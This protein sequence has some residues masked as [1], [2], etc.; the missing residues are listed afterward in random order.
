MDESDLKIVE[1]LACVRCRTQAQAA[2]AEDLLR[3]TCGQDGV[4]HV[5]TV[6]APGE[7][8]VP[9]GA[10]PLVG[11]TLGP[12][13][14][15]RRAGSEGGLPLYHGLDVNLNQ[16]H[17]VRV[18]AGESAR[19]RGQLQ[20][21]I[22]AG[23]MAAAVRHAAVATVIHLGRLE[24]GG[25]FTVG[26][27]LE[28]ESFGQAV[29]GSRRLG[30]H[31]V[32]RV[33]R[34]LAE[35]LALLHDKRIVHRNLG[36]KSVYLLP[37][38][39]PQL[40]NFAFALGAG[41]APD[42]LLVVGQPGYLAPE[43]A[44]GGA[45]DGRADLYALGSLLYHALA[46]RPAFSAGNPA[47]IIRA[48]LAGGPP[49]RAPLIHHVPREVADL[50]V[51]LLAAKPEDRP[52][53]ARAVLEVLAAGEGA[54]SPAAAQAAAKAESAA[55][56]PAGIS[57][58]EAQPAPPAT[59][60]PAEEGV[61]PMKAGPAKRPRE[62]AVERPRAASAA[63]LEFGSRPAAAAQPAPGQ[64]RA[65]RARPAPKPEPAKP[66]PEEEVGLAELVL[67]SEKREAGGA[68][69]QEALVNVEVIA[70]PPF[71]R[72]RPRLVKIGAIA[73]VAVIAAIVA[74]LLRQPSPPPVVSTT[75][76]GSTKA[77]PKSTPKSATAAQKA[78]AALAKLEADAKAKPPEVV[79][80][81]SDE[82][83]AKYGATSAAV[84]AKKLRDAAFATLREKEAQAKKPEMDRL[85]AD[86]SKPY[87]DRIAVADAFLKDFGGTK[88]GEE[89]HKRRDEAVARAES[90]AEKALETATPEAEKRIAA[91]EFGS[92][93]DLLTGL[94]AKHAGTRAGTLAA[95]QLGG[96][97]KKLSALFEE[98]KKLA[99]GFVRRLA[100]GDAVALYDEPLKTWKVPE[101][102][103]EAERAVAVLRQRRAA[104]VKEYGEFL[105]QFEPLVSEGQ[106]DEAL[107]TAQAAAAKAQDPAL[108]ALC[109][110]KAA[111]AELLLRALDRA[112]AGAKVQ[113]Q[114]AEAERAAGKGEGKVKIQKAGSGSGFPAIAASPSRKGITVEMPGMS[115]EVAW[116]KLAREQLIEFAQAAPGEV[117]P[118]DHA[119]L[120]LLALTGGE[121]KTAYGEFKAAAEDAAA[122]ETVLECL[123]R[124]A[125]GLVYV[126]AGE[127]RAGTAKD[128]KAL[129][130]FLIDRYEVSAIE[131]AYFL[132]AVP[133]REPPTGWKGGQPPPGQEEYPAV[134]VTW[135]DA[136]AYAEWLGMRLPTALEW[137]RAARGTDGRMFPWGDKFDRYA[138]AIA[139]PPAKVDPKAPPPRPRLVAV[140]RGSVK[141][142][143]FP[144]V[145]IVGNAREWT[146]TPAADPGPGKQPA[147]YL[148]AGGSAEDTKEDAVR[149]F[150][151]P[152]RPDC[153]A[154]ADKRY[155]FTGFRVAWP[156]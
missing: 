61:L 154:V 132:R 10:D 103:K 27:P 117:T 65:P 4:R 87:A 106:F 66:K 142:F 25:L 148:A 21:F 34:I 126:P 140:N 22:Q 86:A 50:I 18:L 47:D 19:D 136:R 32:L 5:L 135:D 155:P 42:P 11:Q 35:V 115:G 156:R 12:C 104:I 64:A 138:A 123:K 130:G 41:A 100:F 8:E 92:A 60:A 125:S 91:K 69:K 53:N 84:A 44:T 49:D 55:F 29:G 80:K 36:P 99:D 110:G 111:E 6:R 144:L 133:G 76:G 83:L 119:A 63:A 78:E 120:G 89:F 118:A 128:R 24:G 151:D 30:P 59:P 75:Q 146:S 143:P 81:D 129:D 127:F 112:I 149:A 95:T 101:S 85:L 82:F 51:G 9:A 1:S 48:Q 98:K 94:V 114:K 45:V 62:E 72:R 46:G 14:V 37:N 147:D 70:P 17:A 38:G 56:D 105:G 122:Q 145:H 121:L 28:G 116:G 113:I 3:Y 137:E 93:A 74:L 15:V 134:N 139:V 77:G 131:Y 7:V 109:G 13:R 52:A 58:L 97:Q 153:K 102:Q 96:L 2:Q 31:G 39:T 43:Q 107:A 26:A 33:G 88:A 150:V 57:L 67:A 79:L 73:A 108:K 68:S 20:A 23:R 16:P 40:R 54:T 71:W 124:H 90:D 152:A 141:G